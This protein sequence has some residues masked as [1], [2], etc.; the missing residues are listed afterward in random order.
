MGKKIVS[1]LINV[2]VMYI[3]LDFLPDFKA[4]YQGVSKLYAGILFALMLIISQTVRSMI[5]LPKLLFV[6]LFIGSLLTFGIFWLVNNFSSNVFGFS[7][8]YIGGGNFIFFAV[9]RVLILH[10]VN[11]VIL[12][13]AI[14][15]NICSIIIFR[16]K[17]R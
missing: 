15:A 6:N 2:A 10:D 4:P 3:V 7:S 11:L 17:K 1:F 16:I 14:I 12:F 5:G 9:P 13:T 8:S